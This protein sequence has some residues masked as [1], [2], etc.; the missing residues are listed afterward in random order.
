MIEW[1][2]TF[3][4]VKNVSQ[5][6]ME[7]DEL[8][9][10][11]KEVN[12]YRKKYYEQNKEME[13]YSESDKSED[14]E[15]DKDKIDELVTINQKRNQNRARSSVSAE[16]YGE[17]NKKKEFKPR[18][19]PKKEDQKKR[20]E[21]IVS[22]SFIF[23]NLD[24]KDLATV[25]DAIEEKRF[26]K[27]DVVII[28][29]ERGDVL[30]IVEKGDLKCIK[31]IGNENKV[32]RNYSEGESFGELALLY[33]APRA[34]TIKADSDCI[35]WALDRE[36]FNNIVKEAAVKKREQYESFLSQVNILKEIS[37]YELSQICDAV[38]TCYFRA[39]DV[40]IKE[41]D[42]GDNFYILAEGKAVAEKVLSS[43]A[44]PSTVKDYN[45]GEYFGELA[46]IKDE[47]RAASI[48]AKVSFVI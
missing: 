27:D 20:L 28:E 14:E 47:P 32:V 19:I 46:L 41:N 22:K 5:L 12:K 18:V 34:A 39:G 1:L 7:K 48:I 43:G 23:N 25:L 8:I 36:T 44:K 21:Q 4:G 3:V 2:Q 10:L 31:K 24:N 15:E 29:G 45:S 33:N 26:N 17:H 30:Y 6:N 9:L 13:V 37:P 11:R 16:V 40:I 35:L 38:K 42:P